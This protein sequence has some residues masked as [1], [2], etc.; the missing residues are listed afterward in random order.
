[1]SSIGY[2]KALIVDD[3][4][5]NIEDISENLELY[6][7]HVQVV[8]TANNGKSGILAIREHN[9]EVIFLDIEMPDMTGFKMLE[10]LGL[11]P[12]Q[13]IIFCTAHD[14]Y[15]MT[16]FRYSAID[17]LVKPLDPQYLKEAVKRA[18]QDLK[19]RNE[20]EQLEQYRIMF[21]V[22]NQE[23]QTHR[24]LPKRIAINTQSDTILIPVSKI[25]YFEADGAYTKIYLEGNAKS[26]ISSRSLK[27]YR[28]LVFEGSIFFEPHRSYIINTEY[29][30][31]INRADRLAT[32][33]NDKQVG[34]AEIKLNDLYKKLN[35]RL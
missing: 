30:K 35:I 28:D 14:S 17:F 3:I 26:I 7:P 16:A 2:L 23:K 27:H 24:E 31:T 18:E 4:P 11:P 20:K 15:A 1:M 9:P 13:S 32:M 10:I 12:K 19:T 8:A 33:T 21:E 6:C 5:A 25:I 22:L 34:I 29:I